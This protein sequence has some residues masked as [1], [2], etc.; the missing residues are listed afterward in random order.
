MHK[1]PFLLVLALLVATVNAATAEVPLAGQ[2]LKVLRSVE[3]PHYLIQTDLSKDELQPYLD[4]IGFAHEKLEQRIGHNP[5]GKSVVVLTNNRL[6]YEFITRNMTNAVLDNS[7]HLSGAV[8]TATYIPATFS[9][10]VLHGNYD[11]DA[12]LADFVH[13]LTHQHHHFVAGDDAIYTRNRLYAEGLAEL[14]A[15][16]FANRWDYGHPVIRKPDYITNALRGFRGE[17]S[18]TVAA[19]GRGEFKFDQRT[20]NYFYDLTWS[21]C[22]FLDT[23]YPERFRDYCHLID[24]PN[25]VG[26]PM[27]EA[28]KQAFGDI[29]DKCLN[30]EMIEW[31]AGL[32][33][34]VPVTYAAGD[35]SG[36]GNEWI[37]RARAANKDH[38]SYLIFRD[39]IPL[40][41]ETITVRVTQTDGKTVGGA[42]VVFDAVK[43]YDSFWVAADQGGAVLSTR[44]WPSAPIKGFP[45]ST[46]DPIAGTGTADDP[47]DY[48]VTIRREGDLL[49]ISVD[50]K[51]IMRH[52][53]RNGMIGFYVYG[54]DAKFLVTRQ[55]SPSAA[56]R[57]AGE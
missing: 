55:G 17:P 18:L 57:P 23:N 33:K 48:R 52:P 2:P 19:L 51:P 31:L 45:L 41:G 37:G 22:A 24:A 44:Y 8:R 21:L 50:G 32:A 9:L 46:T 14:V 12:S 1:L 29:D 39:L 3:T 13:E 27:G 34:D 16:D 54:T 11:H 28:W 36:G 53:N 15:S 20:N 7:I 56:A 43:F 38:S 5:Y 6:R 30:G 26:L 47:T 4:V 25:A 10:V 40:D 42:G 35:W 49:T